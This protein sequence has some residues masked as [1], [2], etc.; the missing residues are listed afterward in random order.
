MW[1]SQGGSAIRTLNLPSTSNLRFLRSHWTHCGGIS[2]V[3]SSVLRTL[4][5]CPP[6]VTASSR[7]SRLPASAFSTS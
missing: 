3:L 4:F 2:L 1:M 7:L 5:S 6:T